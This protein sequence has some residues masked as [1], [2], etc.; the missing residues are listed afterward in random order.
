M[1]TTTA[2]A[3]TLAALI[4]TGCVDDQEAGDEIDDSFI[5]DGKEDAF[6]VSDGSAEAI[7]VLALVDEASQAELD[8]DVGL[9]SRA[10]VAILRHRQ[11]E[12]R[13]LGTNDDDR[14]ESLAEL[15]AISY[16]GPVAF[17]KLLSFATAHGYVPAPLPPASA[18]P[19]SDRYCSSGDPLMT[20]AD[21]GARFAPGA[22]KATLTDHLGWALRTRSCNAVSG[23]S[24]WTRSD[25]MR[26]FKIGSTS[27]Q[28]GSIVMPTTGR[29]DLGITGTGTSARPYIDIDSNP[30]AWQR[31]TDTTWH[32]AAP[33]VTRCEF[34][35]SQIGAT[36]CTRTFI[37]GSTVHV[38]PPYNVSNL[39]S[40]G[41]LVGGIRHHCLQ[42]RASGDHMG[43]Q[44]E[45]AVY[46]RY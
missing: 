36:W 4:L 11:G 24:A 21:A 28:I 31:G 43:A 18:D 35:D 46:A 26:A 44:F 34:P 15:D 33:L 17:E 8:V 12:D 37:G 9:S 41:N 29:A 38:A 23:C 20:G 6:G 39:N 7:G 22:T 40:L 5:S 2:F 25:G 30:V 1:H 19:F 10:A 13:V 27:Y 32:G 16:V 3:Y 14:I 45:L 42:L